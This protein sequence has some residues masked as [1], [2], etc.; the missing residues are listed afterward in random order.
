MKVIFHLK[1]NTI[2]FYDYVPSRSLKVLTLKLSYLIFRPLEVMSRFRDPQ[3]QVD[4]N[5]SLFV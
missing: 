3:L 4:E 1:W 2:T 5:Y